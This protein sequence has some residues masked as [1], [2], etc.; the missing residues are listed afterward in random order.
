MGH[1]VIIRMTILPRHRNEIITTEVMT[2]HRVENNLKETTH[3][4]GKYMCKQLQLFAGYFSLG[5][6]TCYTRHA[7]RLQGAQGTKL[8]RWG[9]KNHELSQ[10]LGLQHTCL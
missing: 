2:T 6:E 3:K 4:K 5:K 1:Q 7:K 10:Q 9:K 8:H